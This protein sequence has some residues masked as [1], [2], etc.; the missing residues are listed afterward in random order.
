MEGKLDETADC[1]SCMLA[2]RPYWLDIEP[3][4]HTIN[5]SK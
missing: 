4:Q 3:R 2:G 5:I 1:D